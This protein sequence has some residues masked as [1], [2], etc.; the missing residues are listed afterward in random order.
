MDIDKISK[1]VDA[2]EIIFNNKD[3]QSFSF[4]LDIEEQYSKLYSN[5]DVKEKKYDFWGAINNKNNN[6][7][8]ISNKLNKI[9]HLLNYK[10]YQIINDN[11]FSDGNKTD[12]NLNNKMTDLYLKNNQNNNKKGRNK[13]KSFNYPNKNSLKNSLS[14]KD[15]L[16][17]ELNLDENKVYNRLYNRGFYIKNKIIINKIKNDETFSKTMHE[18][19]FID[20]NSKRILLLKNNS[21][22]N[23]NIKKYNKSL[24]Y[25]NDDETFKP[26]INKNSI[27]IV[28]RLHQNQKYFEE[29]KTPFE[30]SFNNDK[31]KINK[32]KYDIFRNNYINLYNYF[33]K[34]KYSNY[35]K[36]MNKSQ[37][38]RIISLHKRNIE[39]YRIKSNE[40]EKNNDQ[41][42]KVNKKP[43]KIKTY[44][45]YENNKKW[46]KLRDEKI[47]KIKE[48]K[49][50]IEL[51]E[52]KKYLD[53]PGKQNYEK[54]KNLIN[55]I[56][57]PKEKE[58][59]YSLIQ[60]KN[61]TYIN[62]N[63]N[64]SKALCDYKNNDINKNNSK[65]KNRLIKANNY[66]RQILKYINNEG[67]ELFLFD[68]HFNDKNDINN[69]SKRKNHNMSEFTKLVKEN[70]INIK[71][72]KNKAQNKVKS[73]NKINIINKDSL[74]YKMKNIKK[75]LGSRNK[76]KKK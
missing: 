41:Y 60:K 40:N 54:F 32:I 20:P 4:D 46:Q 10:N 33:N 23:K 52:N 51:Y 37:S 14:K 15:N 11:D 31:K 16:T 68:S 48:T 62:N 22:N 27:R 18:H 66:H 25:Y 64:I 44:N 67:K 56:F 21:S 39:L 72:N 71:D 17:Y 34:C 43:E 1:E 3:N 47:K 53:L 76:K 9:H 69:I 61:N 38:Q 49:D 26:N 65:S 74:E 13:K 7:K 70:Q 42:N 19:C 2:K 58:N 5:F 73:K 35:N 28:K 45:I 75:I 8:D 29:K 6:K 57:S 50:K 12:N 55:K 24:N 30:H 36:N 63:K 59:T